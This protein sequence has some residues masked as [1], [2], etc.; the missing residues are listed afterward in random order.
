[1]DSPYSFPLFQN[2][3]DVERKIPIAFIR[4]MKMK[5]VFPV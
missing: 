5:N 1:M 2:V 4:A 3:W